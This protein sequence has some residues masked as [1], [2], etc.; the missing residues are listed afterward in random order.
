M[1]NSFLNI[2]IIPI[3]LGLSANESI[4][5]HSITNVPDTTQ[6]T[7]RS[8]KIGKT[9]YLKTEWLNTGWRNLFLKP[10]YDI[11]IKATLRLT[12]YLHLVMTYGE[13]TLLEAT[14][15]FS[16]DRPDIF[17][18]EEQRGIAQHRSSFM[19]RYYPFS[20]LSALQHY[21]FFEIG[22]HFSQVTSTTDYKEDNENTLMYEL[23]Y[24]HEVALYRYRGQLNVGLSLFHYDKPGW[25]YLNNSSTLFSPEIFIGISYNEFQLLRDE[26]T[27][28]IGVAPEEVYTEQKIRFTLRPKVG[29]GLGKQT[30]RRKKRKSNIR[31]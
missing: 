11:D 3:L 16:T 5:S 26:Y 14:N 10:T 23:D 20:E 8:K 18:E 19:V 13:A 12:N 29:I 1:K 6:N 4:A 17:Q 31:F 21:V 22:G 24:S 15:V 2:V 9:F 28:T 27:S 25:D 30:T 7:L